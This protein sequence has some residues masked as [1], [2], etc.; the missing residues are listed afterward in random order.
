MGL[1]GGADLAGSFRGAGAG[2]RCCCADAGLGADSACFSF[3]EAKCR[4]SLRGLAGLRCTGARGRGCVAVRTR[5]AATAAGAE[6]KR[7]P[8]SWAGSWA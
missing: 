4:P 8:P 5:A 6:V 2:L 3:A 1:S 7:G